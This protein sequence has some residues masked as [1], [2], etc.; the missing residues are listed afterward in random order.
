M[1]TKI[2]LTF[3]PGSGGNFFTRCLNLLDNAYCWVPANTPTKYPVTAEEK[4]QLFNYVDAPLHE[5][6]GSYAQKWVDWECKL[7]GFQDPEHNLIPEDAVGIW[8]SHPS[9]HNG[10]SQSDDTFFFYIDITDAF[11]WTILNGLYKTAI[12]TVNEFMHGLRLKNHPKV[13]KIDLAKIIASRESFIDEF[14]KVCAIFGHSLNPAEKTQVITL[15]DQWIQ[16]TISPEKFSEFKQRIGW[17][18]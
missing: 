7:T 10:K 5:D 16:T 17:S 12:P 15:Y 6:L 13:H 8:P 11:E 4:M 3:V 9:V 1:K 2:E 18:L 14:C